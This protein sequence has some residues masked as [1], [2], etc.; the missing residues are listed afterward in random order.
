LTGNNSSAAAGWGYTPNQ[1][2]GGSS[3]NVILPSNFV[4][5]FPA[6]TQNTPVGG[7]GI[8]FGK[9]TGNLVNLDLRLQMGETDSQTRV[10]SRPRIATLDNREAHIKQ[11]QKIPYETTSQAGTQ[12]QFI[13]A[14]LQLKVTPHVTPEGTI[15]MKVLV[16]RDA[17][18]AYRSPV[19]QVPSI[20]N[21][22]AETE[23]LVKDGE[24]LVIGGIYETENDLTEQG[25]PWLMRVP[26]LQWLFKNYE[27]D[28]YKR[29]LLIFITPSIM[30]MGKKAEV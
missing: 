4:V 14:V 5:G 12:V 24:T 16:T 8:S 2:G 28:Y 9:L 17:E 22:E 10:I 25:I 15:L 20:D 23:V 13:D 7:A 3:T 30:V 29:E 26:V 21:R 11:G 6:S 1:A 27:K 19:N 18:G